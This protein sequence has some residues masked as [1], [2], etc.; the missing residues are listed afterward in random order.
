M[1]QKKKIYRDENLSLQSL[2]EKMKIPSHQL[3]K[4]INE[5][6]GKNFFDLINF[7]RI[8][9]AKKI[10]TDPESNEKLILNIAYSVG[11]N[12]KATFYRAFKKLTE[13]TPSLYKKKYQRPSPP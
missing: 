3:S 2:S 1:L 10:L 4:V 5:K 13:M 6:C 9:E 11:F 8:E 7:Y 12:S